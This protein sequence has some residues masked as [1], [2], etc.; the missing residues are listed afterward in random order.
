[1]SDLDRKP[2][3]ELTPDDLAR[4]PVWEYVLDDEEE[5]EDETWVQPVT[6]PPVGDLTNMLI[7]SRA[8]LS[9]G[10]PVWCLLSN[11]ALQDERKT[12]QFLAVT[13]YRDD[14]APFDLARYFDVDYSRRGPDAL[15]AFLSLPVDQVF[16]IAYDISAWADGLPEVVTGSIRREPTERLS[17]AQ[18]LALVLE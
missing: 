14:G 13:I 15:S 17:D 2:I 12:H 16:P 10:Q 9:S 11:V 18:R 4:W 1:M 6:D 7:A 3:S 5:T 8:R